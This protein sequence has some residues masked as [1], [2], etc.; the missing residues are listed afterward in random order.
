MQFSDNHLRV[1]LGAVAVAVVTVGIVL[2]IGT[3]SVGSAPLAAVNNTSY[4]AHVSFKEK[5]P[6]YHGPSAD[7]GR[8]GQFP[9]GIEVQ[10]SGAQPGWY[11]V[12][13]HGVSGWVEQVHVA[14]LP[15]DNT[16]PA[17]P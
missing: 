14:A 17:Q 3:G 6:F 9:E 16:S 1:V 8:L 12:S 5:T 15:A 7:S 4:P 11:Y 2:N 13:Y 10:V